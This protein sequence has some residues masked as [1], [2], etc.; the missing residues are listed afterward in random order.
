M[1]NVKRTVIG[2]FSIIII[3]SILSSTISFFG[4][5]NV[6]N[7]VNSIKVN[8]AYLD[9]VQE[10]LELSY[11][12]QR[13]AA[14]SVTAM[15]LKEDKEFKEIGQS[16]D[17]LARELLA[18]GISQKDKDIAAKLQSI[19]S[20]Y[21]EVYSGNIVE[22]ITVFD[23]KNIP[24]L[25]QNT[26]KL[27]GDI[28]SK[29]QELRDQQADGLKTRLNTAFNDIVDINRRLKLINSDSVESNN[30]FIDIKNLL[31]DVI[32]N[33]QTNETE[34][35]APFDDKNSTAVNEKIENLKQKI[36]SAAGNNSLI[37]DNSQA[38]DFDRVSSMKKLIVELDQFSKL[39]ELLQRTAQYNSELLYSAS[40]YENTEERR[41]SLKDNIE[42][43][44]QELTASDYKAEEMNYISG[45][46]KEY[47]TGAAEISKRSEIL[48]E[49]AISDGYGKLLQMQG[50]FEKSIVELRL[51][52][53]T[54]LAEDIKT[55]E[56]IK[57]AIF[58]IFIAVTLLSII[59]GMIIALVLSKKIAKPI[60]SLVAI[61]S[62]VEKGDL[63]VRADIKAD[64][65]IGG[66]GRKVNNV[67]D[68]QQKMV[69]QFRSTS[70][71]I[72]NLKQRMA[73]LVSQNRESVHK[74][75]GIKKSKDNEKGKLLDTNSLITDVKSV[76]LQTQK[77]V[78]DSKKA[79]E[80]AKSRE[81][82]VEEAELVIN[83]VNETVRSIA[84]SITKLEESSGKIGDITNTITQIA[85]QTNLLALNAAIE[86]NRAGQQ[87]KGFA[88]VADEI[89]KLSN[90]SNQSA[91][92]IKSQIKEIQ[93]SITFAV[94]RMN[95]GVEG[96]ESG[97]LRINEVKEGIAEIID[98]VNLVA[99]A[100]KESADK[101]HEH[102]ESTVQFIES[103]DSITNTVTE[104]AASGSGI[105]DIVEVQTKTIK[106]LDQITRLLHEAS[107][108]LKNISGNVKI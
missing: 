104:T 22:G 105:Q 54:Y 76:T 64:G 28:Y 20:Q 1:K 59:V 78:D 51:S 42:Q 62:R 17:K 18:S 73:V 36:T 47:Y 68:G 91:G 75:S 108:D 85:S 81:K 33:L 66:L 107:E 45:K 10:L 31:A 26:Q 92:E 29:L 98:S 53:N 23:G 52:L 57:T 99:Q 97:A 90:A 16:I 41:N 87:G 14:D 9:K 12:R 46:L 37:I 67:L 58:W 86:A 106:D 60:N 96:V 95:I 48:K 72:S 102:Y 80:V 103:V 30:D 61:L 79:I 38:F 2:A 4:Y 56:Q 77:A 19:N 93:A 55:S 49:G 25:T 21:S 27:Y 63:T 13:L 7:S 82:T 35:A 101:A 100:I 84:A 65:E 88:V 43:L 32:S 50:S 40:S 83:T 44:L 5:R 24:E 89:R 11:K 8:R 69:E 15:Q 34:A 6:I 70:N 39:S 94:E 71:E 3:I 74:I